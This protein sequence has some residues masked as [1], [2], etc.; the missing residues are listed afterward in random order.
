MCLL[1][2]LEIVLRIVFRKSFRKRHDKAKNTSIEAPAPQLSTAAR[3]E[4]SRWMAHPPQGQRE[5]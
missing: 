3:P 4:T 5:V 2:Y 1:K